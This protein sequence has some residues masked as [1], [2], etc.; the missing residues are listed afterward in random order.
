MTEI[1][2]RGLFKRN[3]L[4]AGIRYSVPFQRKA[5]RR[6]KQEPR[7]EWIIS[8]DSIPESVSACLAGRCPTCPSLP[9]YHHLAQRTRR[10]AQIPWLE[11]MRWEEFKAEWKVESCFTMGGVTQVHCSAKKRPTQAHMLNSWVSL[12]KKNNVFFLWFMCF[13]CSLSVFSFLRVFQLPCVC[14]FQPADGRR[15]SSSSEIHQLLD[16]YSSGVNHQI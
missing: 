7:L 1:R 6:A 13:Y 3:P 9:P 10:R 8:A 15:W 14:W 11:W 12:N 4:W 16:I 5:K 2:V